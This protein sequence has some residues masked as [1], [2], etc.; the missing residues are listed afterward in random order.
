MADS[1]S[2][3]WK[4]IQGRLQAEYGEAAY[5]SWLKPLELLGYSDGRVRIAAPT[6]F[7]RDWVETQYGGRLTQLWQAQNDTISGVDIVIDLEHR[8][9]AP[10]IAETVPVVSTKEPAVP[11]GILPAGVWQKQSLTCCKSTGRAAKMK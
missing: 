4:R 9:T 10:P 8:V 3:Q 5:R 7:M 6:R 11:G 1:L 2:G